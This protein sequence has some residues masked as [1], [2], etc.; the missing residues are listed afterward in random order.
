MLINKTKKLF[1]GVKRISNLVYEE[2]RGVLKVFLDHIIR[3][4]VTYCEYGKRKTC[5]AS[6]I[7][8]ALKTAPGGYR[9]TLYGYDTKALN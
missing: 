7:L 6:D 4:A 5:I 8:H 2:A 1:L 9:Q 3:N